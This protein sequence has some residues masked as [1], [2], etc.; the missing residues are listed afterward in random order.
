MELAT[1]RK[2]D[3]RNLVRAGILSALIIVMTVV[4]YTG[5][6]N[7]GLVEITTLHI[8]VAVGAV[9]LGWKYGAVLGFVWGV[10][11]MLRALTNPL[12]APFVNPM[13]CL[14]PRVLVGIA[15]G[16]TAQWLRKLRLRTG[17]VAALS[18]AVAT[19]TNT[20]LVLTAL[21]LFSVVLTG[22]PLL[23]T[24]YAT[25]IGVNGSIELVAAV[26][27]VPAIV[28]AISPREIVLG[29]DIGASTTKFA[30]VKNRK[31]VKEYR[32][33]DE[34]SFEDAL[35]S[36]GYAGVKRIAV[37]GVGSSFIKG[38][39]HGIPTVRKDEFTSVS[40]GA[41]NLVKQSNTLVVSIGTGTSFTR[42]TPVRAWHVGGTGLG[43]GMLRGLSARLCGT[44]DMEELQTLAASGD[45]HAI[46]LQLRDV[47]EG[48]LSHLTP[49]ATVANMS[50][51]SEQTA[52]A[53][54]AAGLCNMI[55][56]SIGLMAVF[57]AKR[58]LTRTIVLV[59]TITDWPIAQRSLDEVAALHNVKFVV[60][61]HAAF[62]TAIGAALSE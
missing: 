19:L 7:Y 52:R 10:T 54:V 38:D 36:F 59:G 25:L 13:I 9:M 21:K 39:L 6:I 41:T 17:I 53:D 1:K 32:K 43:G 58:H 60:P 56:Q 24:I 46:D 23:G 30:L 2:T 11:C 8:V 62:A 40:R 4:P 45:L 3:T 18:A 37:T 20:V 34:Q 35:E 29:I 31:C 51:L 22:L 28:A 15:G 5:Y 14:V 16:L 47:F 49:N 12:W 33:P 26:L 42:I 57:A 55:F 61:D 48:T 27:L 50:K 44:D